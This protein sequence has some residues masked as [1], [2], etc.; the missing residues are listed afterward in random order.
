MVPPRHLRTKYNAQLRRSISVKSWPVTRVLQLYGGYFPAVVALALPVVFL[1]GDSDTFILPRAA[2]V[3]A[4]ACVGIGLALLIPDRPVLGALRWPL[5][6]AAVAALLAFAF[7]VSWPLGVAGS[8]T[9][10]ES[11]PM[12]LSYLGLLAAAAWLVRT[13][14]QREW[15]VG[16]LVFATTVASLEAANQW[17][18]H[19]AFRPDG[20]LGNANLLAALIAMCIPL[21]VERGLRGNWLILG[22]WAAVAGLAFGLFVTTSRSGALGALAGALTVGVLSIPHRRAAVAAAA[23]GAV[24]MAGS[25]GYLLLGPLRS[26][27]DDP[28]SLRLGLW[29]DGLHL[30][31]TRPIT[32]WGEDTTGLVFGQYLSRDY[33]ALVTFDRI[34]SGPLDIAATQ[35]LVGLAALGWVLVVLARAAW[36]ARSGPLVPGLAGALVGYSVWV[37][38]NF[39]WAPATG[40]FWLM[41]GTLWSTAS[42]GRAPAKDAPGPAAW[43]PIAAVALVIAAVV[44]GAFPVIA[45]AWYERGRADISVDLDPLQAQYHWALGAG[46]IA[47]GE[48]GAGVDELR[49]AGDLGEPEPGLYVE[50]GDG[51]LQLGDRVRARR[52]YQ[53]ALEIDPY[54]T[55][56]AQRL[57]AMGAG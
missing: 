4:G 14:S 3:M 27:N 24:V 51:E 8:Y 33:A 55:P 57:S 53:R 6:A 48:L 20:N 19:V 38:F 2:I 47:R 23:A 28:A 17:A 35:G 11:L 32:G 42:P 7:S 46:L 44:L 37:L 54:Y 29:R 21:A 56:A 45:D 30:I 18:G 16:A 40:A 15:T 34:H 10:Y 1:T 50:L 52:D 9:R 22:W 43:Q 5:I 36:R 12:R 25:L 26:V 13:P 49:R 41:A 39:D 31:A